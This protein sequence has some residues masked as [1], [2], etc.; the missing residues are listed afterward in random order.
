ML[1]AGPGTEYDKVGTIPPSSTVDCL[2][3]SEEADN[4][5]LVNYEGQFGWACTDYMS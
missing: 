1:R 5:I 3:R 2:G 4:W